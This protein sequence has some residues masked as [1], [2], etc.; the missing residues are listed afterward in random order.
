M[1]A[2]FEASVETLWRD[3][4]ARSRNR[5]FE[6]FSASEHDAQARR[7]VLFLLD[8]CRVLRRLPEGAVR[9]VH[10]GGGRVRLSFRDPRMGL[11][12]VVFLT[13]REM[14]LLAEDPKVAA[15]LGAVGEEAVP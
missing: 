15:R 12:R 7:V 5:N 14:S 11:S 10:E 6:R 1:S 13:E 2:A 9:V 3:P 4:E 8:L